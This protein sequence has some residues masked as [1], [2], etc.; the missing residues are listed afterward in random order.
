MVEGSV[1]KAGAVAGKYCD[2]A[3]ISYGSH[4]MRNN[5]ARDPATNWISVPGATVVPLDP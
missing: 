3:G 2:R 5:G 4:L 1:S